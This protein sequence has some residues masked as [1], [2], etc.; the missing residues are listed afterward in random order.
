MMMMI[1]ANDVKAIERERVAMYGITI[2]QFTI[3]KLSAICFR[4]VAQEIR[5]VVGFVAEIARAGA[6]Q[7]RSAD[8][9]RC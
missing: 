9:V 6:R 7:R 4:F 2:T 8:A 5:D 3:E 1:L